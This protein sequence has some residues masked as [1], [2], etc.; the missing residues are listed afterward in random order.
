[1]TKHRSPL[2]TVPRSPVTPRSLQSQLYAE[3]ASSSGADRTLR[4]L[5][6]PD[7]AFTLA[8]GPRL[9]ADAPFTRGQS[10]PQSPQSGESQQ[11]RESHPS[12]ESTKSRDAR[13]KPA[14]ATA[15]PA[16]RRAHKRSAGESI[17]RVLYF[18]A[19]AALAGV[20]VGYGGRLWHRPRD[21]VAPPVTAA[22]P[23]ALTL[24]A[25]GGR[26]ELAADHHTIVRFA[27]DAP[28]WTA[29]QPLAIDALFLLGPI[30]LGR[31]ATTYIALDLESGRTRFTWTPPVDETST[32]PLAIIDEP[33]AAD[34]VLAVTQRAQRTVA[35]CLDP[36]TGDVRFTAQLP[37]ACRRAPA[38][39]PGAILVGC[40]GATAIID[41]RHGA[42]SLEPGGF[43]LVDDAHLLKLG[44]KLVVTPWSPAK[45]R[46]TQTGSLHFGPT[47]LA[48]SDAILYRDRLVLRATASS[49]ALAVIAQRGAAP[50]TITAP[51]YRL[52]DDAPFTR[53]CGTAGPPRFQ[54]LAL[55]PRVGASF[56][57]STAQDGALALLD[58]E[59]GELAW[60]SRKLTSALIRAITCDAGRYTIALE[61]P[62]ATG[63]PTAVTWRLDAATGK[64]L[65]PVP[66]ALGPLP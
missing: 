63:A 8:S 19:G 24:D 34:C 62:D 17:A 43:G 11:S 54:V 7:P 22:P 35:R 2:G 1:M 13:P 66:A 48:P 26:I 38:H 55:A 15:A 6:V 27:A 59:R 3:D 4:D 33:G 9:V 12:R 58:L 47:P 41:T 46:F 23:P 5:T 51:A 18:I 16:P 40:D 52:A 60:T 42:V 57:P 10:E 32:A 28:R 20:V 50:T 64:T 14:R 29:P 31:A 37:R 44:A 25:P 45:H 53:R 56:D 21:I 30:V 39:V 65:A 49:D 61:L 36:A